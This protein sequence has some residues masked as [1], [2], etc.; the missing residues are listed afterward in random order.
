MSGA[1]LR[2]RGGASK[3]APP[4]LPRGGAAA[5]T[6]ARR[7]LHERLRS[8]LGE[9]ELSLRARVN[10][11][12]DPTDADPA[13]REGLRQAVAIALEYG[14]RTIET[15][16]E[17]AP[18][19]PPALRAQARMAARSGIGLDTVLRRYF[20]GYALL[21]EL[22]AEEAQEGLPGGA[23][24][25]QIVR[26]RAAVFDRLIAAVSEEYRREAA[27]RVDSSER[28][29]AERIE[30]L[31]EGELLDTA[32]LAYDF[33]AHHTAVVAQGEGAA[34]AIRALA[35]ALDRRALI[36]RREQGVAWGWLGGRRRLDPAEA[37]RALPEEQRRP[38]A[39]ALGEPAEGLV[40]WRL[41]H[42]QAAAALPV[43]LRGAE[44]CLRYADV[45]LLAS[46]LQDELLCA[47]LHRLYLAPL[48]AERDGGASS[49][50]ALRAYFG[51][52]R[53]ASSAAAEVGVSRNTITGRLRAIEKRLGHRLE[54][55]ATELEFTLALAGLGVTSAPSSIV[56]EKSTRFARRVEA[57]GRRV[58]EPS[59]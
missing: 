4:A 3:L 57:L 42:R 32:G 9:I 2:L 13:Y 14:L 48:Q 43:A 26:G 56:H 54:A 20:A 34:E 22:L 51:A 11:I 17:R 35:S 52:G 45:A 39:L 37:L 46:A 23:L 41:S 8:R 21:G 18:P 1:E 28:R 59:S 31:L 25:T 47:S 55:I 30:R 7:A 44:R 6:A 33:E 5:L 27:S 58:H 29:R 53:N 36:A 50:Q 15:G 40:G 12:A 24:P 49:L 10:A 16:E 38:I 19:P